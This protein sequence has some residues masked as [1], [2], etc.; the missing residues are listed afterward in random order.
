M[1]VFLTFS[2]CF[3]IVFAVALIVG[4]FYEK[5]LVEAERLIVKYIRLRIRA[6]KAGMSTEEY[7]E[8][9]KARKAQRLAEQNSNVINLSDYVA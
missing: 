4:Y 6:R 7:V 9:L 8:Y 5:E 2:V 1:S 3:G